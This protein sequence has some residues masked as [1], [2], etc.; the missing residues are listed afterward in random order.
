MADYKLSHT[1]EEIDELLTK[2]KSAVLYTPQK[3]TEEQK[4]QARENIGVV[5]NDNTNELPAVTPDDA[6]KF[7]RVSSSGVW[8]AEAIHNAKGVSF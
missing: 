2:A 1:G 3:L 7:L 8:S 4:A 6:G 5:L